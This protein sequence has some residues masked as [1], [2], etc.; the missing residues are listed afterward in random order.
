MLSSRPLRYLALIVSAAVTVGCGNVT[1]PTSA[2]L[3]EAP[4]LAPPTESA[5]LDL[6]RWILIS[7][8]WVEVEASVVK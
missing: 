6:S 1:G 8:V 4:R 5:D 7:G 3:A 2:D